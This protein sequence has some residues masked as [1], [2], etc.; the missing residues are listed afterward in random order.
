VQDLSTV[1]NPEGAEQRARALEEA[2]QR[3]KDTI[4]EWH[5]MQPGVWRLAQADIDAAWE[6]YQHSP[7]M[8][9]IN[10][11][12]APPPAGEEGAR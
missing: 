7:E 8:R 6:L 5:G 2:L 1:S 9:Q 10:A 4:R 12:L 11:A 3:A